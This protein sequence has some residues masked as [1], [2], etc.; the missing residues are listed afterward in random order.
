MRI[1]V[2]GTGTITRAMVQAIAVVAS[3]FLSVLCLVL[4]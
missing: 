2:L 4:A 3:L 1:G